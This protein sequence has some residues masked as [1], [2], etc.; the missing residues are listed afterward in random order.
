MIEEIGTVTR[1]DGETAFVH[2]PKKSACDGCTAGV[3]RAE[4]QTMEIE[5]VNSAGAS[6]GQKVRVTVA[7]VTYLKGS[8]IVYGIPALGLFAGAVFGKELLS[9]FVRLDPDVLS[10]ICG[11]GAFIICFLCIKIWAG[12]ASPGAGS[13]PTVEEVISR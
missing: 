5:A 13:R 12:T 7:P 3:C 2:V 4:E 10:A 9:R 8:L 11:F 6:V 1:I